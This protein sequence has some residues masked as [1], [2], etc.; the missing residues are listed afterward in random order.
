MLR[1]FMSKKHFLPNIN[2]VQI[3]PLKILHCSEFLYKLISKYKL[4][5]CIFISLEH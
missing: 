1:R 5:L 4:H 3:C 2:T